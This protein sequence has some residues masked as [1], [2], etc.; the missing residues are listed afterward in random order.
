MFTDDLVFKASVMTHLIASFDS[1]LASHREATIQ[2]AKFTRMSNEFHKKF[3]SELVQT[4]PTKKLRKM[5]GE[6]KHRLNQQGKRVDALYRKLLEELVT[7]QFS[8]A[9]GPRITRKKIR[10]VVKTY[11]ETLNS[12]IHASLQQRLLTS[13][14]AVAAVLAKEP[15]KGLHGIRRSPP[16]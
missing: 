2:V 15:P 16:K 14:D 1:K 5:R 10:G 6:H 7:V 3:P 12:K 9:P 8:G 4:M 13:Y 11:V